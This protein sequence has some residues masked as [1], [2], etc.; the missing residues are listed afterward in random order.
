MKK[1]SLPLLVC[2]ALS[3]TSLTAAYAQVQTEPKT[4]AKINPPFTFDF[5]SDSK[6][7]QKVPLSKTWTPEQLKQLKTI[8]LERK[9]LSIRERLTEAG[10][11]DLAVQHAIVVFYKNKENARVAL[12]ARWGA[13]QGAMNRLG[14][15][16]AQLST[17]L[18]DFQTAA[19]IEKAR[20]DVAFKELS[21]K[22]GL[23]RNP[24]LQLF[25]LRLGIPGDE[26]LLLAQP[27]GTNPLTISSE[28]DLRRYFPITPEAH[29]VLPNTISQRIQTPIGPVRLTYGFGTRQPLK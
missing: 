17:L 25:L 14:V 18:G 19:N 29:Y 21:T 1:L 23:A 7:I 5:Y 2:A 6:S 9:A 20:R 27:E 10:F 13:L 12:Q 11:T 4:T 3:L 22:T 8:E 26:T 15:S 24:R 16:E 28:A